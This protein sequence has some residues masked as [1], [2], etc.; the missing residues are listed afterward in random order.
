MTDAVITGVGVVSAFGF[1][2]R[3][4]FDGLGEGRSAIGPI[5]SFDAS[6]FPTRVAGEVPGLPSPPTPLPLAGEGSHDEAIFRRYEEI[7]A[8]RD[9]KV[10]FGILAAVEAWNSARC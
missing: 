6:S 4:F 8:F 7:G 3:V 10:V 1:G 2:T 5:R 9:R